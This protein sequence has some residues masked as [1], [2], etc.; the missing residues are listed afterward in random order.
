MSDQTTAPAAL[1]DG[2][3]SLWSDAWLELRRN[4]LFLLSTM[5][6]VVVAV[7]AIAPGLFTNQ[8]PYDCN[9]SQNF[10]GRPRPGH[11]FGFD[12]LGCDYYTRVIYGARASITIG[13]LTVACASTIAII[14]G[15][16]AGY[17]GGWIDALLARVADVWFAIPTVLGGIVILATLPTRGIVAVTLAL[18]VL[19]WPVMLRLM[20][21]CVL[22]AT[23]AD[24]I[25]AAR[26][27]GASDLRIMRRHILP[28]AIA[29]VIVY[30]TIYVGIIISAEATLTFLGVGL[31]APAISWGLQLSA[32][33][34]RLLQ[35]PHLLLFP[36]LFLSVT[37]LSFILMGDAL[38]DALDPKLR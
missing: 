25:D 9:L 10:L 5:L 35:A 3:A 29:P 34:N 20:R 19:G 28:N 16:L 1:E 24:Y 6:I 21:S 26:A 12:I 14:G 11:P 33:Q 22:S 4:P 32:A 18:S 31:Q 36:G 17:Y 30:A 13:L 23:R 38:R 37:I 15:T 7:M 8:D 2:R 27:L